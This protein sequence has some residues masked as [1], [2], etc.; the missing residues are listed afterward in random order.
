[1]QYRV[2]W[3]AA[4]WAGVAA[5]IL[6]TVAQIVLW[7][8]FADLMPAT[9]FRDARFTAAI[10]L[11]VVPPMLVGALF[12]LAVYGVNMY[13][14]TAVFPWFEATRDWITIAAHL[15]FGVAAAGI[16]KMLSRGQ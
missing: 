4:V 3:S 14:F 1:M 2:T 15:A 6:A 11:R 8:I 12:G 9:L 10:V 16:Y 13:G 7:S 5:G